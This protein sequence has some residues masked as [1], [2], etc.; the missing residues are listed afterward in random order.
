VSARRTLRTSLT[1]QLR[2]GSSQVAAVPSELVLVRLKRP[3]S[4]SS[5]Q[6]SGAT[7]SG[8]KSAP[9]KSA[10]VRYALVRFARVR[11]APV[12][13]ALVRFASVRLGCPA[14]SGQLN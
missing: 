6:P 7:A 12:K 13:S 9:V 3:E 14:F 5:S 1:A 11:F 2:G 8:G 4:V 10:L